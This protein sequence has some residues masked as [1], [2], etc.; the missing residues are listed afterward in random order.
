MSMGNFPEMSSQRILAV[1]VGVILVGRL[2]VP[3]SARGR[4]GGPGH[5]HRLKQ[6][7]LQYSIEQYSI[8]Q[9]STVLVQCSVVQCSVVQCSVV[10]CSVVQ[11]AFV[12][13]RACELFVQ[14]VSNTLFIQLVMIQMIDTIIHIYIY[15]QRERDIEREREGERERERFWVFCN[16]SR[17]TSDRGRA[18]GPGHRHQPGEA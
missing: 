17:Y 7:H 10:Q 14:T 9:Y 12:K 2:A 5:H 11:H 1:L 13:C 18:G 4:A 15:I 8:V 16:Q 6:A 3:T